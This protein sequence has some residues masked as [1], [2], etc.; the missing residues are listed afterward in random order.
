MNTPANRFH[1]ASPTGAPDQP[2]PPAG[3]SG[4]RA[5]VERIA[6]FFENL[7]PAS[8]A[9]L[10]TIYAL[11]ARFKDP[12]N[13]VLGLAGISRIFSHMFTQLDAPAFRVTTRI[14]D[15][16]QVMLGWVFSFRRGRKSIE[17]NGVTHMI[18][19]ADG[20]ISLHRDYW[21]AAEEL[22]AKFPLIGA[23]IRWLSTRLSASAD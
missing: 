18:L 19:D 4:S 6:A 7:S 1:Q 13:D 5:H 15:A 16:D 8:L 11:D 3:L 9:R 20:R 17:I 22:Y 10:D 23:P 14:V 21:D 2:G 12:F